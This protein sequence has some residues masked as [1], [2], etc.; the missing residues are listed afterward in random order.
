M[1]NPEL[2]ADIE[3]PLKARQ[4][5]LFGLRRASR[6]MFVNEKPMRGTTDNRN[7]KGSPTGTPSRSQ[8]DHAFVRSGKRFEVTS[9][10]WLR[11]GRRP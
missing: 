2:T 10:R 5:S 4:P 11:S 3:M 6:L 7:G 1:K 8:M 9:R